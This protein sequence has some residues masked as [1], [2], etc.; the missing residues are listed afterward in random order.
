MAIICPK[1]F[2]EVEHNAFCTACGL[3]F[4]GHQHSQNALKYFTLLNNR[5]RT[6]IVLGVG[7]FGITYIA[8][9]MYNSRLCAIKEYVPSN[10]VARE[11]QTD[12]LYAISSKNTDLFNL[13]LKKFYE[14][15]KTLNSLSNVKSIV[16]AYD[17]FYQNNT[18]YLVMEY[19][20]GLTLKQMV[21]DTRGGLDYEYVKKIFFSLAIALHNIHAKGFLH[22]DISPENIY[23]TSND[24][25]KLLDFGAA[26]YYVGAMST[27][28]TVV[29]KHGYAPPE[30]YSSKGTQG[31]W[32]DIYALASTLYYVYTGQI[33]PSAPD[34]LQGMEMQP[35]S[36]ANTKVPRE[37]E[38]LLKKCLNLDF[39]KRFQTIEEMLQAVKALTPEED[40]QDTYKT[41]TEKKHEQLIKRIINRLRNKKS[42]KVSKTPYVEAVSGKLEGLWWQME[43]GEAVQIGRSSRHCDIVVKH[44]GNVSR[45]HCILWY[46]ESKTAFEIQDC[47]LNGTYVSGSEGTLRLENGRKYTLNT[48]ERFYL[49]ATENCFKVGVK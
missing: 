7:G 8:W 26:R 6:G 1:C 24:E 19:I 45:V 31:P 46:N 14:E 5:Y 33:I 34:R 3:D 9:D 42:K 16:K 30:Q 21:S 27:S 36:Q 2:Q 13:G 35:L 28:L 12:S 29:L 39:K 11:V 37:F 32:T 10:I 40:I 17:W 23:I 22:R 4:S 25:I 44:S 47:S 20:E 38:K 15:A 41:G 18:A 48:K 49:A 43:H